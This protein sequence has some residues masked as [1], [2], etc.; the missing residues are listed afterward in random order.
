MAQGVL[1]FCKKSVYEQYKICRILATV[2]TS[3]T[4]GGFCKT[5]PV[6]GF[7]TVIAADNRNAGKGWTNLIRE[8][9]TLYDGA[10]YGS[11]L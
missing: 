6:V 1:S 10:P 11:T 5:S 7:G 3:R 4:T 2:R 8:G 9:A